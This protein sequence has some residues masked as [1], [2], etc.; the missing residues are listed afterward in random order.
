MGWADLGPTILSASLVWAWPDPDIRARSEPARPRKGRGELFSPLRPPAC[1]TIYSFCI[2]GDEDEG[3]AEGERKVTWRGGGGALAG[4]AK[5]AGFAD[6]AVVAAGGRERE[7]E[8]NDGRLLGR[9][10]FWLSL[11]PDFSASGAWKSN[12]FIG[13]G[14]G[15]LCLF[16]CKI[17]ALG[18]TRKHD[19]LSVL[20][21]KMVGRVGH[22]GAVP[23]P[24]KSR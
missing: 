19:E 1:R 15:T 5:D 21:R 7:K 18:S 23:S 3:D 12:L 4:L 9:M 8:S 13:G 17:L 10:V 22:F 16:W 6:G 20:W 11:D 2:G 24:L 14:R